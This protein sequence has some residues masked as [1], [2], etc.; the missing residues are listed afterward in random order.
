MQARENGGAAADTR[1]WILS[2]IQA[3]RA[4]K[5]CGPVKIHA[6]LLKT[7]YCLQCARLIDTPR[8][9][10]C[11]CDGLFAFSNNRPPHMLSGFVS[12][13]DIKFVCDGSNARHCIQCVMQ[14]QVDR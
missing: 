6:S 14:W 7:L 11:T 8:C 12:S 10:E 2:M 3:G 1:F 9:V 13:H 4:T 5:L